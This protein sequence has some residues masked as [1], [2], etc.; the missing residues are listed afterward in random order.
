MREGEKKAPIL[1]IVQEVD[2]ESVLSMVL[3]TVR[4]PP[5]KGRAKSKDG[6]RYEFEIMTPGG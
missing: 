5:C 1:M 2:N 4:V 6:G 3:C